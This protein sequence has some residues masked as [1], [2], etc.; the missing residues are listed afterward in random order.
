ML[1]R[2]LG[3]KVRQGKVSLHEKGELWS[4]PKWRHA[5]ITV[6]GIPEDGDGAG[7]FG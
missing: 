3:E 6:L 2:H 4:D 7:S 1:S 5:Y